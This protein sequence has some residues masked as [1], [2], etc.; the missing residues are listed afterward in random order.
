MKLL[1]RFEKG[2]R[3]LINRRGLSTDEENYLFLLLFFTEVF[4]GAMHLLLLVFFSIANIPLF[5]GINVVSMS[6]YAFS[7]FLTYKRQYIVS[8]MIA[9]TEVFLYVI[10]TDLLLG[11]RNGVILFLSLIM[12][13]Q[14]I[15]PY[16]K[17]PLARAKMGICI[18][19]VNI[20]VIVL[21]ITHVPHMIME[22]GAETIL[23]VICFEMTFVGTIV[24]LSIGN[25]INRFILDYNL[26]LQQEFKTEA[27]LDPL[28]GL[29]NRRGAAETKQAWMESSDSWMIAMLDIDDFKS[30][31]DT[32]GHQ[33]GDEVLKSVAHLIQSNIRHTDAAFRWGGEE[34]LICLR[35]VGDKEAF[36]ILEK[37]RT[38]IANHVVRTSKEDIQVTVT[39][40][41]APLLR[42]DPSGSVELS[43]SRLYEGKRQGKN[44][45]IMPEVNRAE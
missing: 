3:N 14:L 11:I 40:G 20:V 2:L 25:Y 22:R 8:T 19:I 44:R 38:R 28:T 21:D 32:Y 27:V 41:V 29:K 9:T 15:I 4:G 13:M 7:C 24:L 33:A 30:V 5:A 23:M 16:N 43:D 6:I 26:E 37:I 39:M 17:K 18:I 10:V 36:D 34:F 31:N 45:V 12:E 1:T 42:K 35:N